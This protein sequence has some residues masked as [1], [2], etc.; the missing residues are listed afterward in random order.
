MSTSSD[1]ESHKDLHQ[2]S[3]PESDSESEAERDAR[4]SSTSFI[5]REVRSLRFVLMRH[6]FYVFC[7]QDYVKLCK[8]LKPMTQLPLALRLDH[9]SYKPWHDRPHYVCFGFGVTHRQLVDYALQVGILSPSSPAWECSS[10]V[11]DATMHLAR[12]ALFELD[13]RC[14]YHPTY[15][16]CVCLYSNYTQQSK[17]LVEED[18][19]EVLDIVRKE[20][21]IPDDDAPMWY[22]QKTDME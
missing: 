10:A 2:F 5:S 21:K 7:N 12:L 9:G 16:Y 20:L 15:N 18:E 3:D 17:E 8:Q 1:R 19:K 11:F 13:M 4:L 6:V 22:F 14:I